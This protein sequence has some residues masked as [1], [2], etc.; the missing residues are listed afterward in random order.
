MN[1]IDIDLL[2]KLSIFGKKKNNKL[3]IRII[4]VIIFHVSTLPNLIMHLYICK[5]MCIYVLKLPW[6][7]LK[8]FHLFCVS[9]VL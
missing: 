2:K 4:Y 5:Y 6:N 1:T 8:S 3:F 9:R 7:G